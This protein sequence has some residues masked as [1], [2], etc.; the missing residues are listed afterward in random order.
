MDRPLGVACQQA[1]PPGRA[2]DGDDVR[3]SD[4]SP[5]P[6]PAPPS[7]APQERYFSHVLGGLLSLS[8]RNSLSLSLPGEPYCQRAL[9]L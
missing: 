1:P 2:S 7:P 9:P 5:L 8:V 3:G 4:L 6:R